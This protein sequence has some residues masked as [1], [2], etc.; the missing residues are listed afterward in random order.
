ME[1]WTEAMAGKPMKVVVLLV[2][3]HVFG[4]PAKNTSA[5]TNI[6]SVAHCSTLQWMRS[7]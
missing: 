1:S 3:L 4:L 5:H 6:L 7:K 2:E